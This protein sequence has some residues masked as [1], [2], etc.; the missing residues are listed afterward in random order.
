HVDAA[1]G[2]QWQNRVQLLVAHER[3]A[4]DDRDMKRTVP[5]DEGYDAV[6]ERLPPEVPNL[7]ERHLAAQVVVALRVAPGAAQRA[8]ASD[9]NGACRGVTREDPSPRSKNAFHLFTI[10]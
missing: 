1:L 10:A 9:L 8:L 7:A 2:Q 3:L 5:I 6:D 4:A